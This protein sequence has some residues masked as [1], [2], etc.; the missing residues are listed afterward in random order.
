MVSGGKHV[1]AALAVL[2]IL[3]ASPVL[4]LEQAGD[5]PTPPAIE[6]DPLAA[7]FGRVPRGEVR[8]VTFR[9]RN[10]GGSTLKIDEVDPTCACTV[11]A[12]DSEIA[13]GGTGSIRASFDSHGFSGPIRRGL[14]VVTNDPK[15]RI[16]FLEMSAE[17]FGSVLVYPQDDVRL[18]NYRSLSRR[19]VV[20]VRQDASET[21]AALSIDRIRASSDSISVRA[22]RLEDRRAL[23]PGLPEGRP[24]DWLVHFELAADTPPGTSRH[25]VF[26][27]TGLE[28]D[29]EISLPVWI[30]VLPVVSL[31]VDRLLLARGEG[32]LQG[33]LRVGYDP[34][35]LQVD[36]DPPVLD[37]GLEWTGPRQFRIEAVLRE[38]VEVSEGGGKIVF[39]VADEAYSIPF[40]LR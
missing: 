33:I 35:A 23:P 34:A 31:P 14:T 1:A 17:V 13:P 3:T 21:S 18:G 39:R 4:A 24:G 7:D 22:E 16:L 10:R 37:L 2:M 38:G 25:E 36:A 40:A 9:V 15:H 30:Q 11:A 19:A 32:S 5:A 8:H 6:I 29:P 12:F 27:T 20:L 26:L 28:G